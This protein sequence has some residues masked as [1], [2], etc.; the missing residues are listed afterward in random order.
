MAV[1]RPKHD[2]PS[3]R[4]VLVRAGAVASLLFPGTAWAASDT[5]ETLAFADL[6]KSFGVRGLEFS[7]RVVALNGKRAQIR[8]F[9]A[10]PLKP[11]LSFFV[12]TREPVA[13]CPFCSSDAEWPVDIVVVYLTKSTLPRGFSDPVLVTGTLEV[14]SKIDAETGFVSQIS[15]VGATLLYG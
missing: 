15:I 14:G 5:P 10:P 9:M 2:E 13:L 7:D 6:Y 1:H 4:D 12:L 11:E 8:G 3:R